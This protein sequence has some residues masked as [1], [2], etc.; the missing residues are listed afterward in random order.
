MAGTMISGD[1]FMA[2]RRHVD[3]LE[4]ALAALDRAKRRLLVD[5]AGELVAEELREAQDALGAIVGAFATEDLLERIFA[6]FCIG[7]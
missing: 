7:K 5:N 1:A 4:R 3:A 6:S 2:R